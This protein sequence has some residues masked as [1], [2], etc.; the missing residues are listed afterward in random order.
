MSGL[1]DGLGGL[2]AL[3]VALIWIARTLWQDARLTRRWQDIANELDARVR[4]LERA[5]T[6][7]R[8]RRVQLEEVMRRAGMDLPPWPADDDDTDDEAPD[9]ERRGRLITTLGRHR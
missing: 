4:K 8:S 9:D 5:Y 6:R 2:A 3:A 7:E 1:L